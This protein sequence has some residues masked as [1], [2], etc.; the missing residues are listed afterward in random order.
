MQEIHHF[1]NVEAVE[2]NV[3]NYVS[4][5]YTLD[6]L[7]PGEKLIKH[8]DVVVVGDDVFVVTDRSVPFT[9]S[10]GFEREYG[11]ESRT[12]SLAR[13]QAAVIRARKKREQQ[14][15]QR[16]VIRTRVLAE[17]NGDARLENGTIYIDDHPCYGFDIRETAAGK[18]AVTVGTYGA[19]TTFP[20]RKDGHFNYAKIAEHIALDAAHARKIREQEAQRRLNN[21]SLASVREQLT[22]ISGYTVS[23]ST[24]ADKPFHLSLA[25]NGDYTVEKLMELDRFLK[26]WR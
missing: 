4:R 19:R 17:L 2:A 16:Q 11:V 23:G 6:P 20:Q 18:L 15:Q 25:L 26:E 3:R 7:Q 1:E 9:D 24:N 14:N 22:S 12:V 5:D 10:F 13:Q 8:G 21:G